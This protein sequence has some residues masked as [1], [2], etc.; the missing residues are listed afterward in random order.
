LGYL[1]DLARGTLNGKLI[2]DD[3]CNGRP[4]EIGLRRYAP[5]IVNGEL[6]QTAQVFMVRGQ[7][8]G[9]CH[10]V[11]LTRLTAFTRLRP[12]NSKQVTKH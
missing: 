2:N 12:Q 3:S 1:G 5:E 8:V 7:F 4:L 11:R 6:D 9:F 10:E